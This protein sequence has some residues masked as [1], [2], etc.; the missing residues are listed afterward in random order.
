MNTTNP[1]P[2]A[3]TQVATS[4]Q[5]SRRWVFTVGALPLPRAERLQMA[6]CVGPGFGGVD[7]PQASSAT[8][9]RRGGGIANA[10]VPAIRGRDYFVYSVSRMRPVSGSTTQR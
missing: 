4:V 3:S 7:T 2:K 9:L 1:A 5:P 10:A 8:W 6:T